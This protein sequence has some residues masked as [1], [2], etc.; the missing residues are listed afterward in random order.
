VLEHCASAFKL[1]YWLTLK[2]VADLCHAL[3]YMLH[4]RASQ[5]GQSIT[6]L[7]TLERWAKVLCSDGKI[8]AAAEK[9]S[10]AIELQQRMQ[11]G[12]SASL[13]RRLLFLGNLHEL[14]NDPAAA[15][16]CCR[17]A[18]DVA[19]QA[20]AP[21]HRI[22]CL[23]ALGDLL[24]HSAWQ[25]RVVLAELQEVQSALS[26]RTQARTQLEMME[27]QQ[28]GAQQKWMQ[29][30]LQ[31]SKWPNFGQTLE[32]QLR[33]ERR[34]NVFSR[35][36]E[37]G[38]SS[39]RA[40][41]QP[42][43]EIALLAENNHSTLTMRT[44]L[45][46]LLQKQLPELQVAVQLQDHLERCLDH[47][48]S[49]Q[50]GFICVPIVAEQLIWSHNAM[51]QGLLQASEQLLQKQQQLRLPARL[52]LIAPVV[53]KFMDP[54][55]SA[56]KQD[57]L[58]LKMVQE[59][60]YKAYQPGK[61][62]QA[63]QVVASHITQHLQRLQ[64]SL[65]QDRRYAQALE[66]QGQLQEAQHMY[67][68]ALCAS[69]AYVGCSHAITACCQTDL[70]LCLMKQGQLHHLQEAESLLQQVQDY[71]K[72]QDGE[73][74]SLKRAS[75]V[76]AVA[77]NLAVWH[78][79]CGNIRLAA[80]FATKAVEAAANAS[81]ALPGFRQLAGASEDTEQT[82]LYALS[83]C[84]AARLTRDPSQAFRHYAAAIDVWEQE[85]G[86]HHPMLAVTQASLSQLL[87]SGTRE[88]RSA[89]DALSRDAIATLAG[90]STSSHDSS[91]LA[92]LLQQ[93]QQELEAAEGSNSSSS[94]LLRWM[95][96][97]EST[98][99]KQTVAQISSLSK[100]LQGKGPH[101][102][103]FNNASTMDISLTHL[104]QFARLPVTIDFTTGEL[105]YSCQHTNVLQC[106][107]ANAMTYKTAVAW[108]SL[109]PSAASR[110]PCAVKPT[111][112]AH[113][114]RDAAIAKFKVVYAA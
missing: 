41:S 8:A 9:L 63:A 50:Q 103:P 48:T 27:A 81:A 69:L 36:G 95:P 30:L 11:P 73:R 78:E 61:E 57:A 60:V 96:D 112:H 16:A 108:Q 20:E 55:S 32:Q 4:R 100:L 99:Y 105:W 29:E 37:R 26:E 56:G 54:S 83:L 10:A 111:M 35:F 52:S 90:P 23:E 68:R 46:Q 39:A 45:Q 6:H 113:V 97:Q 88:D 38:S 106:C 110:L 19:K 24:Q 65:E 17:K 77:H 98:E 86:P 34:Y 114:Q 107:V 71:Y 102:L 49:Q 40:A 25:S 58:V 42:R 87:S 92:T 1:A 104:K 76:A 62:Q 59:S 47:D 5:A 80:T 2:N 44:M 18:L 21:A 43:V 84:L 14:L 15:Q 31:S 53:Q 51:L 70:A 13:A 91:S 12:P 75:A 64:S 28:L 109:L 7:P 74:A 33:Q 67:R 72:P 79:H 101:D 22:A 85:L 66:K 89:A 3:K 82:L 93:A 94:K